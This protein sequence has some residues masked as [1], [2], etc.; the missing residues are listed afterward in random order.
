MIAKLDGN[1]IRDGVG[2][3]IGEIRDIT[4]AIKGATGSVS[5]VAFWVLIAR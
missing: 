2:S 3:R 4:D 1:Y 5:D